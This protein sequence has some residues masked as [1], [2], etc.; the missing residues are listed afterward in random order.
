MNKT[1]VILALIVI[2]SGCQNITSEDLEN[3]KKAIEEGNPAYCDTIPDTLGRNSC[4]SAVANKVGDANVCN[5]ISDIK[6]KDG[7]YM[8]IASTTQNPEICELMNKSRDRIDCA[9][10]VS[11]M[12]IDIMANLV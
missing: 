2:V 7:C 6:F 1:I 12:G 4:Y 3:A 11:N 9:E 5:K 8:G 10:M